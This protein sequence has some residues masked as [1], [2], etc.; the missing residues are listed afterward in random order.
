MGG[1]VM[2]ECGN[3]QRNFFITQK[4][5]KHSERGYGK[6]QLGDVYT[7]HG[8]LSKPCKFEKAN[9]KTLLHKFIAGFVNE[10]FG[11]PWQP[12]INKIMKPNDDFMQ[13]QASE[14]G[15]HKT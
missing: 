9:C 14:P 3:W 10:R 8:F 11:F 2:G 5:C 6:L 15:C 4:N 13:L 12:L 7:C 1:I